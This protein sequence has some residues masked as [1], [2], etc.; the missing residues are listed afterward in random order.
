M[1][2]NQFVLVGFAAFIAGG[3]NA[4][5]GGGTFF[6][7]PALLAAGVSPVV[8]NASNTVALCPASL[9]S[10]WAYRKE[11]LRHGRMAWFLAIASMIG[12]LIGAEILLHTTDA[13]F[14]M[15]IPWLLLLATLLFAFSKPISRFIAHLRVV[16][17]SMARRQTIKHQEDGL[18]GPSPIG[19]TCFQ[20]VVGIYGGFFGAGMGILTLAALSMIGYEDIQE[21]NAL[22]NLTSGVNYLIAAGAFILANIISWPYTL[23]MLATGII[24]G[25]LGG[26]LARKLPA[27]WLRRVVIATGSVLSVIFFYK[28]YFQV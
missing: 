7:F 1:E 10:A 27:I 5:A 18:I 28:V 8:A 17:L 9:A 19:G 2:L 16:S 23:V 25:Y 6:S 21:L 12:S 13:A 20:L 26:R 15:L 24:G 4:I 14:T 3:V 22:K 11:A